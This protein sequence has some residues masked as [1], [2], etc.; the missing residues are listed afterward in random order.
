MAEDKIL[1]IRI[2]T[3]ADASTLDAWDE[4]PHVKAATSNDGETSF[5]ADWLEE[6]GPRTDGTEFF[7]AELNGH[8]IGAMQVIDPA[9]ER[10]QYWGPMGSGR[11]A[12]D[13]WIGDERYLGQ[14]LGTRMMH[15]A[16]DRCFSDP[17][18]E[19]ILIDPL[20]NNTP[21]HRFYKRLGFTFVERRQFDETSDCF[22][23][24]LLRA[25]WEAGESC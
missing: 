13:I 25:D 3:P 24:K 14:G 15:F 10:S 18:V 8:P 22:V 2:A 12:L 4:K 23:Y 1:R 11:R 16:I 21:S 9:T 20:S 5:D 17:E 7:I 19:L 6:L